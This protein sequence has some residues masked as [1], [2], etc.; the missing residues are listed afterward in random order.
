MLTAFQVRLAT[1]EDAGSVSKLLNE[2]FVEFRTLYTPGGF[3]AT[4]LTAEQ[5]LTRMSE[6]PVWL[7]V[8]EAEPIGTVAAVQN[9]ESVY[10]RGMAVHPAARGLGVGVR[11]LETVGH[12][13]STEG[14]GRVFLTTTPFLYAAIR[15][16]E[17]HGFRRVETRPQDLFGTPLF[18]MEKR[19]LIAE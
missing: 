2:A 11:L 10:M 5:V 6:G 16:Y 3:A 8:R 17:K 18:T 4:T 12:W 14:S 19:I 7:A 13:A 15:M 9:G 1:R